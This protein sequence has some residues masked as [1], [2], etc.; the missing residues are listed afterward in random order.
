METRKRLIA[1]TLVFIVIALF[2]VGVNQ[3]TAPK[4]SVVNYCKV[5]KSEKARLRMYSGHTY[6]S[7]VFDNRVNEI[8]QYS[9]SFDRLVEVSPDDIRPDAK[10]MAKVYK[11]ME[12][13]SSQAT[14][15]TILNGV[16]A[17]KSMKDWTALHCQ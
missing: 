9:E 4:R 10:T 16:S 17:E 8:N 14:S 15:A 1:G 6:S 7:I 11:S 2:L 13:G 3:V 5:Y 12:S